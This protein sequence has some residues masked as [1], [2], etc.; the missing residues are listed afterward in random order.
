MQRSESGCGY[1]ASPAEE[2]G[3]EEAGDG[4]SGAIPILC[5]PRCHRRAHHQGAQRATAW[6]PSGSKHGA[7]HRSPLIPDRYFRSVSHLSSLQNPFSEPL[8]DTR[9]GQAC[10]HS[11]LFSMSAKSPM[12][13][14]QLTPKSNPLQACSPL[15]P[16]SPLSNAACPGNISHVILILS[17]LP[18]HSS[19]QCWFQGP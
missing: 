16:S 15:L 4:A 17:I 19:P 10:H 12:Q 6:W 5:R 14:W 3:W 13:R 8:F 1:R 11:E 7:A 18:V 9:Q 2:A